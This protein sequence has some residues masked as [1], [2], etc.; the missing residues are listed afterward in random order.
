M[1]A[2]HG[3]RSLSIL[4]DMDGFVVMT[5][6]TES[7]K[8]HLTTRCQHSLALTPSLCS[9]ALLLSF[10]PSPNEQAVLPRTLE[11]HKYLD[12]SSIPPSTSTFILF[13]FFFSQ[14]P[15]PIPIPSYPTHTPPTIT[16]TP[17]P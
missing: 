15:F 6:P 11:Q 4:P 9:Y 14:H 5:F 12:F 2:T 17:T 3:M 10:L 1:Q 13:Y 7:V 16:T 8:L